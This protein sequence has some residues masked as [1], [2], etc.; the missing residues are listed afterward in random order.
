[1]FQIHSPE[2]RHLTT[3]HLAQTM[4]LLG[5]TVNELRQQIESE[6]AKNPALELVE[7][8][9][10][11]QCR[12]KLVAP[13][14]CPV[15]SQPHADQGMEPIIFYSERQ[16][17]YPQSMGTSGEDLP[18]DNFAPEAQD[19]PTYVM[20]QIAPDLPAEDRGIAAHILT[21][22]DEDGLLDVPLIEIARYHHVPISRVESVIKIIQ[23]AEPVGVG[24]R[25]PQ[26]ALLVQLQVLSENKPVPDLAE[27]MIR[28]GMDYLSRHQYQELAR[29]LG[30]STH[31]IEYTARYISDN[32]NP[33]PARS[34]WG[35]IHQGLEGGPMVFSHPDVLLRLLDERD[36]HSPIVAEIIMPIRGTL[37]VNPMFRK[38]LR[39]AADDTVNEWRSDLEQANLLV[40]C[41]QQ[42]FH[43][44]RRLVYELITLQ[45]DFIIHGDAELT[46]MTRASLSGKLSVH[47]STISRAVANKTVQLPNGHIIPM[48][49]FFD[50]SLQVRTALREIVSNE[51]K[52]LSDTQLAACLSERGYDIA[53]RTV[54]KYRAMEGI[55]P[56]RLRHKK[57]AATAHL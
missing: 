11:P 27:A 5:L 7:E 6:L 48:D 16:E 24:S 19:L 56:A 8:R 14:P 51:G 53:R 33:F 55:L 21:T 9:R 47:E 34:F 4:T 23:R 32:L 18:D 43:T 26:E 49:R 2:I 36:L 41:I 10:C 1:M 20:R 29:L 37:R 35:D 22:L 42:R 40:K 25:S 44:I 57:L 39:E 30:A 46:P 28:E 38:A 17:F 12:R 54:A 50:R 3:A 45:R 15:C 31:K 52:P 13:G